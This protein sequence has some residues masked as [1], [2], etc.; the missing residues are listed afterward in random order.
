MIKF[1]GREW[2]GT[3]KQL[4]QAVQKELDYR[5]NAPNG[6]WNDGF[7]DM[8]TAEMERLEAYLLGQ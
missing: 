3:K 6:R 4:L 8:D 1:E 7:Y 5:D 2:N